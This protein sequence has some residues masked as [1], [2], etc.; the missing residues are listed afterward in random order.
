MSF[1]TI[2]EWAV[3]SPSGRVVQNKTITVES[4]VEKDLTIPDSTV[5][6]EVVIALDVSAVS[7]FY[8]VSD[9]A[10]TVETNDGSSPDDTLT[11]VANHPYLWTSDDYDTFLLDTADITALYLT[12]A[13]G[14]TANVKIR[15]GQDATP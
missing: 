2:A 3:S 5:D 7:Y 1:S 11:L 15:A 4:I 9:Q 13:S 6:Q 10:L 12:N 8:I 14:S